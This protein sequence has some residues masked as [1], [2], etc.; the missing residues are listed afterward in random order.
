[1]SDDHLVVLN[2]IDHA[3]DAFSGDTTETTEHEKR[4][5]GYNSP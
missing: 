1:M 4:R 5:L 2:A 3:E